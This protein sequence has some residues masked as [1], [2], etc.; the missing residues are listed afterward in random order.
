MWSGMDPELRKEL[1]SIRQMVRLS[2][3]SPTREWPLVFVDEFD[4]LLVVREWAGGNITAYATSEYS[5][6]IRRGTDRDSS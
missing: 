3:Q 2:H 5:S 6:Q 4:L 1:D